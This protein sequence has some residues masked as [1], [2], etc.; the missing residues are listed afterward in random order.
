[1]RAAEAS[2][3]LGMGQ[4]KF[5]EL[6]AA[7]RIAQPSEAD[8]LVRWERRDLDDYADSLHHRAS[9]SNVPARPIRAV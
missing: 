2:A 7:G 4:T 6:V 9:M 8:G 1:M 3:Y 5:R